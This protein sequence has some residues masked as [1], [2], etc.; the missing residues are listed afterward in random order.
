MLKLPIEDMS[1]EQL[2]AYCQ[3]IRKEIHGLDAI[4]PA[5][6]ESDEF[7]RWAKR[8]EKLEDML[9]DVLDRMDELTE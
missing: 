3:Q 1:M 6:E 5:D 8:H 7:Q 2:T 9:D 4:E